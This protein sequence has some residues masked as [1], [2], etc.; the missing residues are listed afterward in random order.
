[1]TSLEN[2]IDRVNTK[3]MINGLQ[4]RAY[5]LSAVAWVKLYLHQNQAAAAY[6]ALAVCAAEKEGLL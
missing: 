2:E 1:M 5:E 6:L 3:L 4:S